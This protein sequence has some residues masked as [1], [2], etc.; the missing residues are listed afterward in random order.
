M[1]HETRDAD[2]VSWLARAV[3]IFALGAGVLLLVK[4]WRFSRAL[5]P[6]EKIVLFGSVGFGLTYLQRNRR[7]ALPGAQGAQVGFPVRCLL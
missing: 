5:S 1:K 4:L 3:E 2:W 6:T 7:C